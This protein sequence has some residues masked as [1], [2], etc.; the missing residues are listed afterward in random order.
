MSPRSWREWSESEKADGSLE[1]MELRHEGTDK[2][3][4]DQD[5]PDLPAKRSYRHHPKPDPN[6]PDRPYSA[7]V[8]FS[9]EM[10]EQWKE[11][12]L[13]FPD[14]S[15]QVGLRWQSLNPQEKER[16]KQLVTGP[17]DKY[18][19]KVLAYQQTKEFR[20]YKRYVEEFKTKQAAKQQEPPL[21]QQ[22]KSPTGNFPSPVPTSAATSAR[23]SSRSYS[24]PHPVLLSQA[25]ED[26]TSDPQLPTSQNQ[27]PARAQVSF[28]NDSQA[29][30]MRRRCDRCNRTGRKCDGKRP[31][32]RKCQ[33]LRL[34]CHFSVDE[35]KRDRE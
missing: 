25:Q 30:P 21:K 31:A 20:D 2:L 5:T 29:L 32:C 14:L 8:L 16:W 1:Q 34:E 7:Y 17:W 4:V 9:N 27:R 6:A 33:E 35:G 10:R 22:R 23:A 13:P 3:D 24:S 19:E 15:R 26:P 11:E 28:Q 18:K 12:N